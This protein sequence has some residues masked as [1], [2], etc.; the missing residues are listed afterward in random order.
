MSCRLPLMAF[1]LCTGL[2]I[3][4]CSA[5][6]QTPTSSTDKVLAQGNEGFNVSA[7]QNLLVQGDAAVSAGNLDQARKDYDNARDAS[8]QLLSFYR[9]FCTFKITSYY[10]YNLFVIFMYTHFI[11]ININVFRLTHL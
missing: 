7:V 5:L 10:F 2:A 1:A 8:K 4:P 3:S 6:A 9:A 11:C